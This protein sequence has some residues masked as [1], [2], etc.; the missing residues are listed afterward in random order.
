M[1]LSISPRASERKSDTKKLRRQGQIPAIIY[2]IGQENKNVFFQLDEM[3]AILRQLR[4]GLLATTVFTLHEGDKTFKALVK[5]V[6]Y[7]PAS[8]AILHI[9]FVAV[10]D[11]QEVTINIPIQISGMAEC[12]GVKLGGFMRPVIRSLKARCLMKDIPQF[13]PLDVSTLEVGQSR[14]LATIVLPKGV[15]SLA[16]MN[17]V[18]VVIAKKV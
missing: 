18:A 17:E 6:Q 13:L 5:E 12:P 3:Q 15:R 11:A 8:Y 9:D 10:A 2:G 16:K 7:H 4:P 1:K 14:T